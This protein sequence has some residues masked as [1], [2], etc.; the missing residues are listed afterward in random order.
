M[1][2]RT[3]FIKISLDN[4][5]HNYKTIS[6][7]TKS[8]IACVVKAD[9]YGHGIIKTTKCLEE[10]GAKHFIVS[11]ID[12][13]IILRKNNIKGNLILITS[14]L[15]ISPELF[16]KYKIIPTISDS[17]EL[18]MFTKRIGVFIKI[19][20]GMGR[21]GFDE[22]NLR[23]VEKI[24]NAEKVNPLGIISHLSSSDTKNTYTQKQ[25]KTF[26]K[27]ISSLNIKSDTTLLLSLANSGGIVNYKNAHF[28]LV[29]PGLLLYGYEP[30]YNQH[31]K[32]RPVMSIVSKIVH[33]KKVKTGTP[34]SYGRTFITKRDS[35]LGVCHIGYA[36]G[37]NKNYKNGEV[38][39]RN[40][41]A[42]IVGAIC[43]DQIIIDLTDVKG[44]SLLDDVIILG[45]SKEHQIS[46]YDI[47]QKTK[48]IPYE[49]VCGFGRRL[50]KIYE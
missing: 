3:S 44:A 2:N 33:I 24:L 12:E 20:T 48:T 43:M 25:I 13:G 38:I 6:K 14:P 39:V 21:L 5:K 30:I 8:E 29:R 35:I 34:I 40:K 27:I 16:Y 31:S 50:D 18:S 19:D 42:P 22:T 15:N 7:M 41:K 10:V 23:Q 37:L 11:T 1:P 17:K 47:A 9:A 28:D 46:A 32:L 4:L 45:K 26:E 49:V 36:D